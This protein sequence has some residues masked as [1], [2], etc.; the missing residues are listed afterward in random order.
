MSLRANVTG[1]LAYQGQMKGDYE[2]AKALYEQALAEGMDKPNLI[3]AYGVL[4]MREGQF[5]K[6]IEIFGKA[7]KA[8]PPLTMRY[9]IR[10]HRAI[11]NLKLG[12]IEHAKVALED[13]HQ[14]NE[15]EIIY[16]T[17]GYLY[18]ITDDE[19]A[20]TFNEKAINLYPENATI[21]DNIGQ[22][23]L[24]KGHPEIAK[25]FLLESYEISKTKLDTNYHL[26]LVAKSEG[27]KI[28]AVEYLEAAKA[29]PIS[30]LN[31]TKKE[32]IEALYKELLG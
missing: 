11:A 19:K 15:M 21:L 23:Y 4:L 32:D 29:C 8:K 24:E 26:A 7:L 14:R 5:E 27:D 1:N 16:E 6:A 2:K 31:D 12:N 18:I 22:Y 28:K 17:L 3:D 13:I 20:R 10:V 9:T 30:A 25:E